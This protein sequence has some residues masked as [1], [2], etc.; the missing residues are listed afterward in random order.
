MGPV[1]TATAGTEAAVAQPCTNGKAEPADPAGLM[2]HTAEPVQPSSSFP[3]TC[4]RQMGGQFL[5]AEAKL[6]P[7]EHEWLPKPDTASL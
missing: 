2:S 1:Y 7:G 4:P 3:A 5:P 6:A